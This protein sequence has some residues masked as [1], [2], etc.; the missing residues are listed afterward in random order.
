M[1]KYFGTDQRIIR[2]VALAEQFFNDPRALKDAVLKLPEY[3][4]ATA[5]PEQL[6]HVMQT[7]W[8]AYITI[9]KTY[10]PRNWLGFKKKSN[11][12]AY[13]A[14]SK[15][16]YINANNLDRSTAS[17][18]GTVV[19]ELVHVYDRINM[20]Y[21]FGHGSNNSHGKEKTFPYHLGREAKRWVER[22]NNV[23]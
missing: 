5:S 23:R 22:M 21:S 6:L 15:E 13:T 2:G 11:V 16:F 18:V 1:L 10:S 19:H 8:V 14:S 12:L 17:V 3:D 20:R 9:V 7:S 4:Y